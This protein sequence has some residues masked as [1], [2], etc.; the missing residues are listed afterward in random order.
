MSGPNRQV[1]LASR[2]SGWV[3]EDNFRIVE[4]PAPAP[5]EG[6]VLVVNRFL[7]LDPY[8]RGRMDE[9]K[10]YAAC[11]ALGAVMPGGTVGQVVDSRAPDF[12]PGDWV[13]SSLGWQL[14]GCADAKHL[15]RIDIKLAPPSWYLGVLGMPGVTAWVG[16]MDIARP[17][18]GETVVVS[19]AAGAVGGVAGQLAR[20]AGCR[21]VGIAGGAEKCG[22]CLTELQFDACVDYK[23]GSLRKSLQAAA[24]DGID[25]YFENVGG[26]TLD[27]VLPLMNAFSRIP[28][29]GLVSQYNATEAYGVRNFRYFLL[30]RI[31]LQ[32]FIVS[33]RMELWRPALAEL[34]R[35]VRSGQ[36]KYRECVAQGL[37]SAPRAFIGM[38]KG[39]NAGKQV[40]A[41]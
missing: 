35:H 24:P 16:L 25:I 1:L 8:M 4:T 15:S 21:V 17:K 12:R 27:A 11:T 14:Y 38:L 39:E 33:D 23:A 9:A 34:A 19:A 5:G 41:L 18:A 36:L 6:E 37:D 40:V 31:R 2:P 30:S 28:L 20:L 10:G 13:S 22:Y 7:S 3:T 29:C 32:G 26:E